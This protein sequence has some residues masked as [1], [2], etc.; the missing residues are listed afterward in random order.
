[1]PSVVVGRVVVTIYNL[2]TVGGIAGTA[3]E[4]TFDALQIGG[5]LNAGLRTFLAA[6]FPKH[7]VGVGSPQTDGESVVGQ[8]APR[9]SGGLAA[10]HVDAAIEVE[11]VAAK[12]HGVGH[13]VLHPCSDIPVVVHE[14]RSADVG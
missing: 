8:H 3:G 11:R 7:V 14:E 4:I 6:S 12:L 13:R 2:R 1:M 10:L 9:L 5:L